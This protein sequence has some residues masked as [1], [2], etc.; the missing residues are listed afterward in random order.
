MPAH[1]EEG[2]LHRAVDEVA[3]GLQVRQ[4]AF[5]IVIAEN[6]S[7]DAT[8]EEAAKLAVTHPEVVV[9]RAPVANYGHALRD[10]F[11][12]ARGDV[13][14]NFDVD[15][16]DLGF[17]DRAVELLADP[18]VAVVIGSKRT[19]GAED[20]RIIGRRMVTAVFSTVMTVAFRLRASDTHG[21]K[22]LRRGPLA[23]LVAACR[24]GADIFDTELIL[25]AERA[26]LGVREIPVS[27]AD[28]RPPRTPIARRIPRTL[29]G[30]GRLWVG[31]RR[32]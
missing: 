2:Y 4:V 16:V 23:P 20:H 17:L 12:A 22:A 13:V 3:E 28:Q 24:S 7:T 8:G 21:L 9:L 32:D 11:L 6:G 31:L 15:L 30:L 19:A 14:V 10:G 18:A 5:E 29:I 27:V 1:N 25:R 26:G